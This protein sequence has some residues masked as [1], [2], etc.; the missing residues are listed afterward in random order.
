MNLTWD[1]M[2]HIAEQQDV[3][4]MLAQFADYKTEDCAVLLVQHIVSAYVT[5][6][7]AHAA[8]ACGDPECLHAEKNLDG[9][10]A[11][12]LLGL[13]TNALKTM[14]SVDKKED[15]DPMMVFVNVMCD[16]R[17]ERI[18]ALETLRLLKELMYAG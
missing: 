2:K 10:K 7:N 12:E 1:F 4:E 6:D 8:P 13:A 11:K 15:I 5:C 9:Q 18:R 14:C 3:K 16:D 17:D